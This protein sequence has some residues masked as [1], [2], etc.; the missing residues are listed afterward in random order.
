MECISRGIKTLLIYKR[1]HEKIMAKAKSKAEEELVTGE[2][3]KSRRWMDVY[4]RENRAVNL[5]NDELRKY[6]IK[7]TKEGESNEN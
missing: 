6:G 1:F 5:I 3:E 2:S 7:D 4:W